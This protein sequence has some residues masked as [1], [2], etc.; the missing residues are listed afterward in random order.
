VV[1]AVAESPWQSSRLLSGFQLAP[2]VTYNS[3]HPFNLLAGADINGDNHFTNDRP[4]GAPRN[5]G[6]GPNYVSFDLRLSRAIKIAEKFSLQFMA[7]SFNLTNRTN[8]ARVNNIVGADFAPP[9]NVH[10]TASLS[11]SQPLGFTS[12]LPKREIQLGARLSF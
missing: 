11:P 12:A 5:S 4:P 1:A 10:G 9:F 8:Y 2:I 6:L 7:E 3:G